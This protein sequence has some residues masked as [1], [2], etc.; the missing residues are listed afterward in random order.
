MVGYPGLPGT[1]TGL[2]DGFGLGIALPG[3]SSRIHPKCFGS[4]APRFTG[5]SA[6]LTK[7]YAV[8]D[9]TIS[10]NIIVNTAGGKP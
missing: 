8:F 7:G 1:L 9:E 4:P 3:Y 6:I 10:L 5:D 2:A